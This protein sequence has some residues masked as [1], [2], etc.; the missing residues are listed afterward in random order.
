MISLNNRNCGS[1]TGTYPNFSCSLPTAGSGELLLQAGSHNVEVFIEGTGYLGIQSGVSPIV[2]DLIVNSA[3]PSTG[4]ENGGYVVSVTGA[5][6]PDSVSDL[7]VSLCGVQAQIIGVYNNSVI[8]F[9]APTCSS[10]SY[11][12]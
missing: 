1:V 3:S 11:Q 2:Y 4:G 12:I 7:S 10:G 8:N 5:G 9:Y 6:F